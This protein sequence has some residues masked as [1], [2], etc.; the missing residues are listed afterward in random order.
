MTGILR[1]L[2]PR[3]QDR[4]FSA[5]EYDNAQTVVRADSTLLGENDDQQAD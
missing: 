3:C 5:K 2:N 4:W 1:P